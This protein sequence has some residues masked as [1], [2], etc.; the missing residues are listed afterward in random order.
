MS[1]CGVGK[2][3]PGAGMG[4]KAALENPKC[5][6]DTVQGWGTFSMV[7][8]TGGPYCVAPAPKNN[9][10]ATARGVTGT[11]IK[12]VVVLPWR[13]RTAPARPTTVGPSTGQ[14]ASRRPPRPR[15]S[16]TGGPVTRLRNLGPQGRVHVHHRERSRR[17]LATCGRGEGRTGKADVRDQHRFARPRHPRHHAGEGQIHRLQLLDH[18]R[19]SGGSR[20]I[21]VGPV[22]LGGEPGE[23][24]R[25]RR[26]ATG[27][28][29]GGVRG[30]RG[31]A[32]PVAQVRARVRRGF[33]PERVQHDVQARPRHARHPRVSYAA[34]GSPLGD[35]VTAD[36]SGSHPHHQ[37]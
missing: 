15:R 33:R 32:Q 21:P 31:D 19:G 13:T 12:V 37:A 8:T 1:T 3:P 20:P 16:T 28:R 5:N 7:T 24:R 9:G 18:A 6:A 26:T 29:Q 22:Q 30:R 10:G 36:E 25:V 27:G 35:P 14:P 4:T 11:T 2:P 23:R 34:N 17:D